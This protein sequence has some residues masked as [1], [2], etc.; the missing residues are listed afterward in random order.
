MSLT[1]SKFSIVGLHNKYDIS[2]PIH[3]NKLILI[4]VNGLGK[5]TVVNFIYFALTEQWNRLIEYE[6]SCI[7]LHI[8]GEE[9]VITKSDIQEKL[10]FA[11]QLSK[12]FSSNRYPKSS[13]QQRLT[14]TILN[15]PHFLKIIQSDDG[16]QKSLLIRHLA[17][18][19]DVPP[20]F[21]TR[22]IDEMSKAFQMELFGSSKTPSAIR[23][24]SS[25]LDGERSQVI[26]LPTYRRI[27]QDLKSI[28][29]N[30]DEDDLRRNSAQ[31]NPNRQRGHIELIQFGMQDVERKI[32][33]ELKDI[34]LRTRAQ[35][36][37]LLGSYLQD[38]IRNRADVIDRTRIESMTD[39]IVRAVLSRVDET[40]LSTDDKR[41]VENAINRLKRSYTTPDS[42][43][44]YLTYFFS[45]LFDIYESLYE[46]EQNIRNVVETCNRY[47]DQKKLEYSDVN[48]TLNIT[49]TS[50]SEL[51]WRTLSSGEKQVASLFTHLHL[52]HE[53]SLAVL[54]DEPELSLSV[55]WQKRLLPDIAESNKCSLLIAVTHSPFIYA[56]RLEKYAIDLS[57]LIRVH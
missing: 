42:R 13:A 45:R 24:L 41:E 25:L 33:D 14:Y 17:Q 6:F 48:F 57:R 16:K 19:L 21:V 49:D 31:A 36:S 37:S 7:E 50:G 10:D 11:E 47:F 35:L 27:E 51:N 52:S 56:N 29:P 28:F 44:F 26:Y 18:E 20:P 8:N 40:T 2:I 23:Q 12:T 39:D 15:T 54:I 53:E 34:Q 22:T 9:V 55:P 38:I 32:S 30:V 4:G 46:S 1:L 5:T 43:D 3:E